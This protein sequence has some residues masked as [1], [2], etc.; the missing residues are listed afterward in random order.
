MQIQNISFYIRSLTRSNNRLIWVFTQDTGVYLPLEN[1]N[2]CNT[3]CPK[4]II[5][6]EIRYN[7]KQNI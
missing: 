2:I 5:F 1:I 3:N 6:I 4:T 7:E